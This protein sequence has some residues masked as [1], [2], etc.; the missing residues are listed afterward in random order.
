MLKDAQPFNI[1]QDVIAAA[2][3]CREKFTFLD[4]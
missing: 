2:N 4:R 3:K 1:D